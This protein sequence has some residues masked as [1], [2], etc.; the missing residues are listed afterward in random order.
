MTEQ[1]KQARKEP[2]KKQIKA[3]AVK[4]LNCN[5]MVKKG[6]E[7]TCTEAEYKHF[8]SLGAV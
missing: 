7:F 4:A 6:D 8:K 1:K 2:A 3:V 5:G